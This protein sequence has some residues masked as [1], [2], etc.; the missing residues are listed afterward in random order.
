MNLFTSLRSPGP[1]PELYRKI[2]AT[3][4]SQRLETPF[5]SIL[6]TSANPHEGKS[7]TLVNLAHAFQEI[8]RRILVVEADIR[9]PVLYRTLSLKNT[10]G[11]VDFLS[12]TATFDQVCHTSSSGLTIIPG[13]VASGDAASLLASPRVK[14]LLDH[15]YSRFDLVLADT[16]PVLAVPDNLLLATV[17]DRVILVVKASSTS[18]RDLRD[19]LSALME[20]KASIGILGVVLNQADHRDVPYYQQRYQNYYGPADGKD[21]E[22]ATR[23][24]GPLARVVAQRPRSGIPS[25]GT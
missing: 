6:V 14:E 20:A 19:T 3:V 22:E 10:P 23:R 1:Q 13:Q 8:G 11:L 5:R 9:R 21:S 7:T 17:F 24:S 4:E 18:K 12:G 25:E 16:P 15:A 2:R